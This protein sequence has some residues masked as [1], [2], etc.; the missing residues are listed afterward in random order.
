M[1]Q[2][3]IL[4]LR[5]QTHIIQTPLV[6]RFF[7]LAEHAFSRAWCIYQNPVKIFI[8]DIC[9]LC[10]RLI[11]HQ[12][13]GN[14]HTLYVLCQDLGSC[15]MYLI[16]Y[17]NPLSLHGSCNL[18]GLATRSRAQI[19]YLLS[20][21]CFQI[22]SRC[23]GTWLLNIINACFM[24]GMLARLV[25]FTVIKAVL[26]PGNFS[27][28]KGC[29]LQKG[30]LRSLHRV[31]SK[32]LKFILLITLSKSRICFTQ[33]ILHSC[34]KFLRQSHIINHAFPTSAIILLIL[35]LLHSQ[36]QCSYTG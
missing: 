18:R 19:Q 9:Q 34:L 3:F 24:P 6:T 21:L 10:C 4:S 14:P 7:I 27:H 36:V 28:C 1:V 31:H 35:C 29:R 5:T 30:L 12:C 22:S 11:R 13:M 2:Y 8:K 20:W 23:H 25:L 33:H 26:C 32:R 15:R 16:T 17:Q